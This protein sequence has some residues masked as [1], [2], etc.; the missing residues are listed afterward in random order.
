MLSSLESLKVCPGL[1]QEIANSLSVTKETIFISLF[2]FSRS[3][4]LSSAFPQKLLC[5]A[6]TELKKPC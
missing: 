1:I 3:G 6:L 5:K 4:V 2:L